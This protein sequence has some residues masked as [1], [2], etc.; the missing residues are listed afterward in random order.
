MHHLN[1]SP[2]STRQSSSSQ[3]RLHDILQTLTIAIIQALTFA[4][5]PLIS[6]CRRSTPCGVYDV[7]W[8]DFRWRQSSNSL[9]DFT[10]ALSYFLPYSMTGF[11]ATLHSSTNELAF[12][13]TFSSVGR[14]EIF[15][16]NSEGE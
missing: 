12:N 4:R 6:A 10:I 7:D 2:H 5:N 14:A 15:W 9:V 3:A 11:A 16:P 13:D 1:L 8:V